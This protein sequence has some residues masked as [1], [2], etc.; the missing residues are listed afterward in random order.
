M[1]WV[2]D[3]NRLLSEHLEQEHFIVLSVDCFPTFYQEH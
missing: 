2:L 3:F 1:D